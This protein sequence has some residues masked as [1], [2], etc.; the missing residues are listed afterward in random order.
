MVGKRNCLCQPATQN[1]Q[2]GKKKKNLNH[3]DEYDWLHRSK[4]CTEGEE[5]GSLESV[6]WSAFNAERLKTVDR[7]IA[8]IVLML[9]QRTLSSCDQTR[10]ESCLDSTRHLN[11]RQTPVIA[12][13]QLLFARCQGNALSLFRHSEQSSLPCWEDLIS[14]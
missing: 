6:S 3:A 1:Q 8:N 12:M 13:A 10:H 4:T 11:P 5:D 9:L 14:K 2:S 7:S